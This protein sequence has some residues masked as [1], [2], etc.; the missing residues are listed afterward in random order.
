MN[1]DKQFRPIEVFA[2]TIMQ[3]SLVKSL[4]EDEGIEVFLKDEF[5]GSMHPWYA[6]AGGAGAVKV[7]VSGADF[8]KA[9]Q[10]VLKYESNLNDNK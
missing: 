10:V 2:G 6:S 9:K 5:V 7:V 1:S 4:L 8:E 3:A